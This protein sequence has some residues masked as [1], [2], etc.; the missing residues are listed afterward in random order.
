LK[1]LR[2]KRCRPRPSGSRCDS[3][4]L[5][6][7]RATHSRRPGACTL[8][9][10]E[11]VSIDSE[12]GPGPTNTRRGLRHQP[13]EKARR[14]LAHPQSS[15]LASFGGRWRQYLRGGIPRTGS[16]ET[17]R[18]AYVPGHLRIRLLSGRRVPASG[19][20]RG[21]GTCPRLGRANTLGPARRWPRHREVRTIAFSCARDA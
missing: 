4:S 18:S 3:A 21:V 12:M 2:G 14:V 8:R 15:C 7:R 6:G 9:R 10:S 5:Q 13:W 16:R 19:A 17:N 20:G 11:P 1:L